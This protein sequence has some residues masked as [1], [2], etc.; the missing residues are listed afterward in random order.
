MDE[1]GVEREYATFSV[2]LFTNY[3][4]AANKIVGNPQSME[5]DPDSIEGNWVAMDEDGTEYFV[6]EKATMKGFT[7]LG[8][9]IE[10]CFQGAAFFS[11]DYNGSRFDKFSALLEELQKTVED[12]KQS[13][14]EVGGKDMNFYIQGVDNE[15]YIA[16]FKT[17]FCAGAYSAV[18]GCNVVNFYYHN[19]LGIKPYAENIA[20]QNNVFSLRHVYLCG[21]YR[22]YVK[23]T[24]GGLVLVSIVY[25]RVGRNF[26]QRSANI[27]AAR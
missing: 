7:V 15:N 21:F 9:D 24:H 1:D 4:S 23:Q 6:Y 8:K 26:G 14:A 27:R 11:N 2:F 16:L 25:R 5:L 3:F 13:E 17:C 10:P 12:I 22:K 18:Y 19:A 20:A